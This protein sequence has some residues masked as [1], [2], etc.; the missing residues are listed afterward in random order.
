M[1]HILLAD[2]TGRGATRALV[3]VLLIA[4]GVAFVV[5]VLTVAGYDPI[6]WVEDTVLGLTS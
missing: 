5:W 4:A 1:L 2:D 6:G 3:N